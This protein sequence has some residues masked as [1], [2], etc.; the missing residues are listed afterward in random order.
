MLRRRLA[1]RVAIGVGIAGVALTLGLVAAFS[2]QGPADYTNRRELGRDVVK[3]GILVV[4]NQNPITPDDARRILPVLEAIRAE[5]AI[6]EA[7]ALKL[8]ADLRA[9]LGPA[10]GPAMARVRLPEAPP[11]LREKVI[12]RAERM[13][14]A[15]PAR[16]GRTARAFDR[17]I[18]FFAAV[19]NGEP[20]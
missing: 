7:N 9:A 11:E 12:A 16:Q 5:D 15:N 18:G 2:Q 13:G 10:L 8:D 4:A 20:Q 6:T 1:R 14:I 19:A 17:L 3:L